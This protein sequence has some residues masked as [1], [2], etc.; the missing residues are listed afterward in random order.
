MF[1]KILNW[2]T[3]KSI[4][5]LETYIASKD[6]NQQPMLSASH[7]NLFGQGDYNEKHIK[8]HMEFSYCNG[9]GKVCG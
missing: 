9:R 7:K 5:E 3:P 6:Q 1:K 2:L 4:S 8:Q